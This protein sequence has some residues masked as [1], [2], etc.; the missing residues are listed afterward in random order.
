MRTLRI[1]F[2]R[3]RLLLSAAML[4]PLITLPVHAQEG[5]VRIVIIPQNPTVALA[6]SVVLSAQESFFT[7]GVKPRIK[8]LVVTWFSPNT[9]LVSFT[10]STTG[11]S[12]TVNGLKSGIATITATS[13]PFQGS[14]QLMVGSL[15]SIAVTPSPVTVPKGETQAFAATGTFA[16]GGTQDITTSVTWSSTD[17]S[18]ATVSNTP[19][20][21]GVATGVST[22]AS[23][24]TI[25]A[26]SGSV[27][28]TAQLTVG[29]PEV[30]S[31]SVTP[32]T[33]TIVKGTTQ[34]FSATAN[35]SDGTHD[36]TND[37][38]TTWTSLNMAVATMDATK[39][40]ANGAG[41]GSAQI[42]ASFGGKNG[43][44]TL[45]VIALA[46]IAV[47]PANPTINSGSTQQF[48]ATG[49]FTDN[50]T[51]NLTNAVTWGSDTPSVATINTAGLAMGISGG[52]S[53]I[54]AMQSGISG[55]T[56]LTV[57]AVVTKEGLLYVAGKTLN[58]VYRW[59]AAS[60]AASTTPPTTTISATKIADMVHFSL[61]AP[62][63]VFIEPVSDTL[64]VVN[65][66]SPA[67]FSVYN[68]A[69]TIATG[70]PLPARQ[71]FGLKLA[72]SFSGIAVDAGRN[73]LYLTDLAAGGPKIRVYKNASTVTG[74]AA[75]DHD[76]TGLSMPEAIFSDPAN[77]RIYVA[78]FQAANISIYDAASTVTGSTTTRKLSG[79]LTKLTSPAGVTVDLVKDFLYVADATS[80][81]ILIWKNASTVTGNT[82]PT[83]IISGAST[84]LNQPCHLAVD[85]S[86]DE[87]YVGSFNSSMTSV[88]V[89][90]GVSALSGPSNNIAPARTI[91][92]P[93][94]SPCGVAIDLTRQ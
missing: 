43:Q 91:T 73:V 24:V 18:T 79:A 7:A 26:T 69:S 60:T 87:L 16:G 59:N 80:N 21:Q 65:T 44:G 81:S 5:P 78:D 10:G 37:P 46:S 63:G 90:D 17:T 82:A 34:Q 72:S 1:G 36:V 20:S 76:I 8:P 83:A 14:T 48:T 23:A 32:P 85:S 3:S 53:N 75:E 54:S 50:S 62:Q 89:F 64:Y 22:N 56:K 71:A 68:N 47:M 13:G 58:Q 31:V 28:G 19:G 11:T 57:N 84:L 15:T 55:S 51:Q 88:L 40:L 30:F 4:L 39:G 66:G 67:G 42:Q 35:E 61:A 49:T 86:R 33:A 74:N 77:D 45:N 52:T 9:D 25:T 6:G 2:L 70:A 29:P 12:I 38:G 27:S 92:S 94:K 41:V 93:S